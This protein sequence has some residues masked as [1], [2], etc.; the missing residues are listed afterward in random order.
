MKLKKN[1]GE[2]DPLFLIH[3]LNGTPSTDFFNLPDQLR[4]RFDLYKIGRLNADTEIR[5]L[6]QLNINSCLSLI[7]FKQTMEICSG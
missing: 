4:A 1:S 5:R 6:I 3:Y 7:L 2:Y